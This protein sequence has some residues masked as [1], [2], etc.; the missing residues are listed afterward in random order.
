M[1]RYCLSICSLLIATMLLI[2][3]ASVRDVVNQLR[4]PLKPSEAIVQWANQNDAWAQYVLSVFYLSG[5]AHF[6]KNNTLARSWLEKSATTGLDLAQMEIGYRY[7]YGIGLP[8]NKAIA[9]QW[10]TKAAHQGFTPAQYQ[11]ALL[12]ADA[13]SDIFNLQ[14]AQL[15]CSLAYR[16]T[17]SDEA[18]Q[19]DR[20]FYNRLSAMPEQDAT[21]QAI[22]HWVT[23]MQE[24]RVS[25]SYAINPDNVPDLPCKRLG[26]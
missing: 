19:K 6:P 4:P 12:Y 16:D 9:I 18:L 5:I 7:L 11:L 24:S 3:C 23:K 17:V 10:F 13:D 15:W 26:L 21:E 25:M 8:E 2:S 1:K 20:D 14:E 22:L